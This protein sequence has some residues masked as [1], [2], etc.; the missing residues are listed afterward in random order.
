[1]PIYQRHMQYNK[2][3]CNYSFTDLLVW[4]EK[5]HLFVQQNCS[6]SRKLLCFFLL[7]HLLMRKTVT[8]SIAFYIDKVLFLRLHFLKIASKVCC[9]LYY[10][11]KM[12]KIKRNRGMCWVIGEKGFRMVERKSDENRKSR[13]LHHAFFYIS[14]IDFLLCM[15]ALHTFWMTLSMNDAGQN[16]NQVTCIVTLDHCIRIVNG[17]RFLLL[18][19]VVVFAWI[20]VNHL[21]VTVWLQIIQFHKK[22]LSVQFAKKN[23]Y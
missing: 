15:H 20:V 22:N 3:P 16:C 17:F 12:K 7:T 8:H 19:V 14:P 1:M 4:R 21:L 5:K 18:V 11:T 10:V 6:I 13:K 23:I 9:R 2:F